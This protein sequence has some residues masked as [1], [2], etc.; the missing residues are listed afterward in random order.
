MKKQLGGAP[1]RGGSSRPEAHTAEVN[2]IDLM[3]TSGVMFSGMDEIYEIHMTEL[4]MLVE[5]C[6]QENEAFMV[7]SLAE[8][9]ATSAMGPGELDADKQFVAAV[10]TACNRTCKWIA[11]MLEVLEKVPAYPCICSQLGAGS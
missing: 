6:N 2:V 4:N 11:L 1:Q 5:P 8:A 10:D 7:G 3:P 9:L